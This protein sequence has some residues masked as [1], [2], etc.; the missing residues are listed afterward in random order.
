MHNITKKFYTFVRRF[1]RS[2]FVI[3]FIRYKIVDKI[4]TNTKRRR[5]T[6]VKLKK[7]LQFDISTYIIERI[8][9]K[10]SFYRRII[11]VKFF[12]FDKNIVDR[13]VFTFR[14]RY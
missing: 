4:L 13:V 1:D 2:R 10:K 6:F 5:I 9:Q 11:V 8:L 3:T 7:N 14:Y 12:L